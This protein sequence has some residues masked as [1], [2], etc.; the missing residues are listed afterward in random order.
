[1][2]FYAYNH[3]LSIHTV[4]KLAESKFRSFLETILAMKASHDQAASGQEKF[5]TKILL[6]SKFLTLNDK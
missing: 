4:Q 5:S 1:M 6:F 3:I 2:Y